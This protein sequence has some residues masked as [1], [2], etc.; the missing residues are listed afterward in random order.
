MVALVNGG[1]IIKPIDGRNTG[2]LYPAAFVK[3]A[4][5]FAIQVI[6][7]GGQ[8]VDEAV[9]W[10]VGLHYEAALRAAGKYLRHLDPNTIDAEMNY[11]A[12]KTANSYNPKVGPFVAYYIT[13]LKNRLYDIAFKNIHKT[14]ARI[15][16]ID[17][18]L[19]AEKNIKNIFDHN[20]IILLKKR[21]SSDYYGT[22]KVVH[23]YKSDLNVLT[24][25]EKN[26]L[27]LVSQIWCTNKV[28]AQ[29]MGISESKVSMLWQRISRK[30]YP[31]FKKRRAEQFDWTWGGTLDTSKADITAYL[32]DRYSE[33]GQDGWSI[34]KAYFAGLDDDQDYDT[35]I[36]I[37]DNKIKKR[38]NQDEREIK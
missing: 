4:E 35:S 26:L 33:K 6:K 27:A 22:K 28:I 12:L 25:E 23:F 30:L 16:N 29:R 21:P 2:E 14:K 18:F 9:S 3:G 7:D 20:N 31:V 32:N 13:T 10:L 37:Q 15:K 34:E 1:D 17:I 19:M 8:G 24:T 5:P 11:C 38:M 36:Y